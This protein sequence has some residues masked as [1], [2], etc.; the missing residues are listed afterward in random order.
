MRDFIA[1]AF[2]FVAIS[3]GLILLIGLAILCHFNAI[4]NLQLNDTKKGSNYDY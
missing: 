3:F 2:G 1:I 4:I